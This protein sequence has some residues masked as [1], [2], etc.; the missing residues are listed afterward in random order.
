MP[1][2]IRKATTSDLDRIVEIFDAARR[3]M[4][5]SGNPRQWENGYPSREVAQNDI[6]HG[7]CYVCTSSSGRPVATFTLIAGEEPAY[8]T[9]CDGAW[10]DDKPYSTLHRLASD[11]SVKGIGQT[12]IDWCIANC[13]TLRTDTHADNLPM[14][15][16]AERNGFVRCG[17][18]SYNNGKA[19]RIAYQRQADANEN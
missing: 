5:L 4:I 18:V 13:T 17:T 16:L 2:T 7:N 19:K 6:E 15:R 12:C 8:R 9:I 14:Q 10:L 3:F 11:G 1:I